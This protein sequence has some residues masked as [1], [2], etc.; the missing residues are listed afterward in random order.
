MD[1]FKDLV[2]EDQKDA[3]KVT[4]KALKRRMVAQFEEMKNTDVEV[5]L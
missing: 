4:V 2:R 3:L 1:E 5:V